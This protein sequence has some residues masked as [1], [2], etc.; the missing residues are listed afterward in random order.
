MKKILL[1][2][3]LALLTVPAIAQIQADQDKQQ[4]QAVVETFRKSIINKDGES[5]RQLFLYDSI[6]WIGIT[7]DK[8]M[9]FVKK[10]YPDKKALDPSSYKDFMKF[11]TSTKSKVEEKFYHVEVVNDPLIASVTFDYSLWVDDKPQNWGKESWEL[12]K[13]D[14]KWKIFFVSY[15]GYLAQVTPVPDNLK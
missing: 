15:S 2:V 14:G 1:W 12:I 3:L 4:I 6:P 10:Y 8:S 11:F 13:V 7:D 5:F 9:A